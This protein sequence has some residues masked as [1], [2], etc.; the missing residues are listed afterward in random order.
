MAPLIS[1][2]GRLFYGLSVN[3]DRIYIADAINY[4]QQGTVWVYD[5]QAELVDEW[6]VGVI[7]SEFD[8][9]KE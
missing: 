4:V 6:Q 9:I 5:H 1:S 8:F 7:P 2:N 3:E